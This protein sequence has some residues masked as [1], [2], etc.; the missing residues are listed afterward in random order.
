LLAYGDR[1]K[2]ESVTIELNFQKSGIDRIEVI[3]IKLARQARAT[4]IDTTY[5][6]A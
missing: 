5:G 6:A 2:T 4:E 3:L 1:S